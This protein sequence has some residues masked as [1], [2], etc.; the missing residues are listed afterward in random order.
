[1]VGAPPRVASWHQI[2]AS[3]LTPWLLRSRSFALSLSLSLTPSP[4]LCSSLSLVG[5][6]GVAVG[7]LIAWSSDATAY[8]LVA[9]IGIALLYSYRT[10]PVQN[11]GRDLL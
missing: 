10:C 7:P 8:L 6:A 1:V 2:P 5:G 11:F 3:R 9:S 4:S